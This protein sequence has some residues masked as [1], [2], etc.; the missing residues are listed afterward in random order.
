MLRAWHACH[1][2]VGDAA[3]DGGMHVLIPC[4]AGLTKLLVVMD[5][6]HGLGGQASESALFQWASKAVELLTVSG[7]NAGSWTAPSACG[8]WM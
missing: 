4:A 8:P 5:C 1:A 3:L 2:A 6:L 7:V